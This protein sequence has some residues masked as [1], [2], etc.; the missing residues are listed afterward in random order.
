MGWLRW[1]GFGLL[2]LL[3]LVCVLLAPAHL[4]IREL[5][6][7]P[8]PVATLLA[9][10]DLVDRPVRLAWMETARQASFAPPPRIL[11]HSSFALEWS[12]GRLLLVDLG[13]SAEG[14]REFSAP[15]EAL[16]AS[17][18]ETFGSV[19]EQLGRA[20]E[21]VAG[22]VLTHLHI[23]HVEGARSLCDA[24]SGAPLPV[25]QV[26]AQAE[27]T[28]YTTRGAAELVDDVGC[29]NRTIVP[30]G[31]A[32]AVPGFPG[33]ALIH[34]AGHTPGSQMLAASLAGPDGPRRVL[35][36]GDVVND[37]DSARLGR[38]K[39]LIYR[40]LIVPEADGQLSRIRRFLAG[41]E[42]EHGFTLA[43]AHDGDHLASLGLPGVSQP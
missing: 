27:R 1:I 3:V 31:N 32:S 23:D 39:P 38:P 37:I 40:L 41:L 16:G 28:N 5:D 2:A 7:D 15:F 9:L 30:E 25:F 24:R 21:R 11:S 4:E 33:V 26:R 14:A 29:L 36:T 20:A 18:V 43:V 6:P 17:P 34:A 10:D 12:D 13:M 22:V 42:R 8:P 19:G 35:F